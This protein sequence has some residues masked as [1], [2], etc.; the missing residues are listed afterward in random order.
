MFRN[1]DSLNFLDDMRA[2]SLEAPKSQ[3]LAILLS[4]YHAE[5][6]DRNSNIVE[7]PYML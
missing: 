7:K 1:I 2:R 3:H 5:L 4:L 6:N